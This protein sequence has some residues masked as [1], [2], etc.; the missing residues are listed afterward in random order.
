ML[1]ALRLNPVSVLHWDE[2]DHGH[3]N[4]KAASGLYP[5]QKGNAMGVPGK[6]DFGTGRTYSLLPHV[7]IVIG[8]IEGYGA[9]GPESDTVAEMR[10]G[11]PKG[12]SD[13]TMR[14]LEMIG[15]KVKKASPVYVSHVRTQ[16]GDGQ[17]WPAEGYIVFAAIFRPPNENG[18]REAKQWLEWLAKTYYRG[19]A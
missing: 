15:K 6:F 13:V 17:A 7:E 19:G 10:L 18:Y 9:D 11:I 16:Q 4:L 12:S 5:G 3:P 8:S 14:D 1:R 2:Y